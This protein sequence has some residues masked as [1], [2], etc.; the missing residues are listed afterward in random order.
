[1]VAPVNPK[2]I[3]FIKLGEGGKWE[4]SCIGDGTVRLGYQSPHHAASLRGDWD[5]VREFWLD[6]RNGNKG[7][8][9]R[10]VNQIRDF[11]E[12]GADD[13]WITF[14]NK[15]LYWCRADGAVRELADGS[16]SRLAIGGWQNTDVKGNELRIDRLD[17]RV[18]KVRGYQ[19][20]ICAVELP[21]YVVRKINGDVQT[22]VA[23]ADGAL[24]DLRNHAAVLIQGLGWKD[25]ELLVELVFSR[26]GWQRFS[27]VG[28][29]EKDTDLDLVAP[30][31]VL[32]TTRSDGRA[33]QAA[34]R[35]SLTARAVRSSCFSSESFLLS[36]KV[37][38][39]VLP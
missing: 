21:E 30:L 35:F 38:I 6:V 24:K 39:G 28:A 12:L 32:T 8:A 1:M 37:C 15:Y 11:Y 26:A 7:A 14:H 25:F 19:G 3:R 34:T 22:D 2:K 23:A 4:T 10:D 29:T 16:R 33:A 9:T 18:S 17:G 27:V 31:S 5:V 13:V 36:R 20:T